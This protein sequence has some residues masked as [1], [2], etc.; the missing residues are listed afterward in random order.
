M[1]DQDAKVRAFLAGQ[2]THFIFASYP[3]TGAY[4]EAVPEMHRL[5]F[6]NYPRLEV[7]PGFFFLEQL[8]G[9]TLKVVDGHTGSFFHTFCEPV[10]A[11]VGAGV[12]A[13][14]ALRG[15]AWRGYRDSVKRALDA[16]GL[17][18]PVDFLTFSPFDCACNVYGTQRFLSALVDDPQGAADALARV[19][20]L[21]LACCEDLGAH[22]IKLTNPYGFESLYCNDLQLCALSPGHIARFVLPV[23]QALAKASRGLIAA[24]NFHDIGLVREAMGIEGLIGCAV[25]RRVPLAEIREML[26]SRLFVA[27]SYLYDDTTDRPFL[28]DG[29]W[30]NPIVQTHGRGLAEVWAALADKCSLLVTV[31]RPSLAEVCRVQNDLRAVAA[32][33]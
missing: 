8:L 12:S 10:S 9:C 27:N 26:G 1:A 23:Y 18:L 15:V 2:R 13:G 29:Q 28:R 14:E 33:R 30:W 4:N 24:F 25:D 31:E 32:L 6:D 20:D 19:S 22:G 5:G 21:F 11:T 3:L 16:A 17:A 7:G